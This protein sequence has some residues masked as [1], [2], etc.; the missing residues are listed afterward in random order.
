MQAPDPRLPEYPPYDPEQ[1]RRAYEEAI[2]GPHGETRAQMRV[3]A[4]NRL[5]QLDSEVGN[6]IYGLDGIKLR[7][8]IHRERCALMGIPTGIGEPW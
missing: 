8:R 3:K 2:V 4:L 5:D 6:D 1:Q 7:L